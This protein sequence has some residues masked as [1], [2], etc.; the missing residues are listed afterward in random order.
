MTVTEIHREYDPFSDE[1]KADPF[2]VYEWMRD[3]APVY[4]SQRWGWWAL[5]RFE[6]VRAAA[7]DPATFLSFEGIDIDDTAKDQSGPGFLPDIDTPATTSCG[8]SSSPTS[9]P[10]GSPSGKTPSAP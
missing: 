7:T 4:Y 3:Q 9:C 2:P 8:R 5:S 1:F 6:D 10:A